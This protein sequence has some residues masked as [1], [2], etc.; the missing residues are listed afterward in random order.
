MCKFP[1]FFE[2]S[3]SLQKFQLNSFTPPQFQTLLP[4]FPLSSSPNSQPAL[5][6][7]NSTRRPLPNTRYPSWQIFPWDPSLK[8][9]DFSSSQL[10]GKIAQIAFLGA[11][12]GPFWGSF[13]WKGR[14]LWG[15]RLCP[16]SVFLM[17]FLKMTVFSSFEIP[18]A[19]DP[20]TLPST[21][22]SKE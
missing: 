21:S 3:Q 13:S 16:A 22:A 4:T 17:W 10:G 18:S 14:R 9:G 6:L 20:F 1:E 15:F 19:M 11:L 12:S 5:D 8:T 2:F 7:S